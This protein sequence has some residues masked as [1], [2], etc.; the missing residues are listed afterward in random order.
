[1]AAK[2]DGMSGAAF[3]SLPA[4]TRL[5]RYEV[6]RPIARGGMGEVYLGRLRGG[7]ATR[8]VALKVLR[9]E[10]RRDESVRAMFLEEAA[11]LLRLDH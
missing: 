7:S 8:V 5:G 4:G 2:S 1:M 11:T 9:P 10:F 3:A 6:I